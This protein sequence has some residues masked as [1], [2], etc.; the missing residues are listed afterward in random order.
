[1]FSVG[2]LRPMRRA[3]VVAAF[4]ALGA[5]VDRAPTEPVTPTSR[6]S[7]DGL[8]SSSP[9]LVECHTDETLT[10]TSLITALG[11]TL[12]IGG[13]SVFFPAGAVLAQTDFELTIPASRYVEVD[14]RAQG[15]DHFL[16]EPGLPAVVTIDYS[17]CNRSDI[18]VKPLSVWYIDS[19][20]K[21]LKENLGGIDNKL[22]RSITFTTPHLSGYAIAF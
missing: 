11:G 7:L 5:C 16:F 15:Y 14:I 13:T 2:A 6:G 9:R 19:E 20:T 10:A 4:A 8:F 21:E 18:L 3:L 1:M 12:S 17:R 22:T